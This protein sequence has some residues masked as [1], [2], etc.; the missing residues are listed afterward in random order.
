MIPSR[1][2]AAIVL[3][4]AR[5]S[6]GG[7]FSIHVGGL[8]FGSSFTAP[9]DGLGAFGIAI[10]FAVRDPG[11]ASRSSFSVPNGP[12]ISSWPNSFD[13]SVSTRNQPWAAWRASNRSSAVR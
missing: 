2:S 4:T 10:V 1:S 7:S 13:C 3:R 11:I 12:W 6:A 5:P 9:F 8:G